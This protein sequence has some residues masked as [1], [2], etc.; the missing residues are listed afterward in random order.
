VPRFAGRRSA[1]LADSAATIRRLN[2]VGAEPYPA[3]SAIKFGV[4]G[5]FLRECSLCV[6]SECPHFNL[7]SLSFILPAVFCG[8]IAPVANVFGARRHRRRRRNV[9]YCCP[10][11]P[12]P[13]R[14][15][16]LRVAGCVNG[17]VNIAQGLTTTRRPRD[18]FREPQNI[19]GRLARVDWL[20]A[21]K[22]GVCIY[23]VGFALCI[24]TI[25][26]HAGQCPFRYVVCVPLLH[27]LAIIYTHGA[28]LR[29]LLFECKPGFVK[30]F[31]RS[32][33]EPPGFLCF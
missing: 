2:P 26:A 5:V 33:V 32:Q 6:E 11:R 25:H 3:P 13:R 19:S 1:P 24:S 27:S 28:F 31:R 20:A 17:L 12:R 16:D 15:T 23:Y 22:R 30:E 21:D 8:S 10:A 14:C 7:G 18:P 9:R 29:A 4:G